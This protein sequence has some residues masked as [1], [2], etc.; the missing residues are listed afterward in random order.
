M[1]NEVTNVAIHGAIKYFH[2]NATPTDSSTKGADA[3]DKSIPMGMATASALQI[4][5]Q[6]LSG[7][8]T[9]NAGV[10]AYGGHGAVGFG[11]SRWEQKAA[12][13][14][15]PGMSTSGGNSIIMRAGIGVVFDD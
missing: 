2:A 5:T 3:P 1:T 7:R 6:Y 14:Y 15:D 13:S 12:V 8:A 4:V 9:L 10:A 11:A